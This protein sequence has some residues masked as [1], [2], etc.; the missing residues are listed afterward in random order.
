[1]AIQIGS[2]YYIITEEEGYSPGT[3]QPLYF[4]LD[5]FYS[6]LKKQAHD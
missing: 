1:M 2:G 4:H 6:I 5:I 3:L